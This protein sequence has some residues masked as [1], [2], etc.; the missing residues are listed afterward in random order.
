MTKILDMSQMK[1][2]LKNDKEEKKTKSK[3][4]KK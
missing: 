1:I 3:K 2:P 4:T